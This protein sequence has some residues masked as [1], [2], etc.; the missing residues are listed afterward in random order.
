[1]AFVSISAP[2]GEGEGCCEVVIR[3]IGASEW[4]LRS[5]SLKG[6]TTENADSTSRCMILFEEFGIWKCLNGNVSKKKN[7][8]KFL[9]VEQK[10]YLV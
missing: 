4:E 9:F 6:M 1:V 2:F 3:R 5:N 8:S 7:F 10:I